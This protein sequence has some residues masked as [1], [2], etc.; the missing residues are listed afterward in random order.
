M[1]ENQL[2]NLALLNHLRSKEIDLTSTEKLVAIILMTHRNNISMMCCPGL[3][4]LEQETKLN[5]RTVQRA[6]KSL[7]E[8]KEL[9][10]LRIR[11]G[12][13]FTKSQYYFLYDKKAAQQIF[14]KDNNIFKT[15]F[16]TYFAPNIEN[17]KKKTKQGFIYIIECQGKFKIGRA[18]NIES[19][20]K[21]Y[22]TENPYEV[23]LLFSYKV[24]DYINIETKIHNKFK[25]QNIHGEW[26]NLS[27]DDKGW[28]KNYVKQ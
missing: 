28:I 21:R 13:L 7:I 17:K 24:D 3:T 20:F 26:F 19:R 12:A 23:N 5:R 25:N 2:D 8:K 4:L 16:K 1:S 11:N 22:I 6:I 27:D 18:K 10:R 14:H 9:V 15:H